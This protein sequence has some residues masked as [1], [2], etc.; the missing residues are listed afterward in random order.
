[1]VSRFPL[2]MWRLSFLTLSLSHSHC[3]QALSRIPLLVRRFSV[4]RPG[5]LM[6]GRRWGGKEYPLI[7]S[8]R[9][10]TLRRVRT[11]SIQCPV[12]RI[13]PSVSSLIPHHS[14]SLSHSSHPY[15]TT[16]SE[17]M[18][19]SMESLDVDRGP[20]RAYNKLVDSGAIKKDQ[21]QVSSHILFYPDIFI[22]LYFINNKK[23]WYDHRHRA[24]LM[25]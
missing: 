6:G 15:W 19:H 2:I 25:P 21:R 5:S 22:V 7:G 1:M 18:S 17:T 4:H 8:R 24:S 11:A 20:L 14:L 23:K 12:I 3:T 10:S 13:T 9:K 16:Q